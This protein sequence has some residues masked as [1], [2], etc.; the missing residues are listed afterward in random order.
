MK[1]GEFYSGKK[2]LITGHT[3]FKGAWLSILLNELGADIYGLSLPALPKALFTEA[4]I[5]SKVTSYKGDIRDPEVVVNVIKEVKPDV[6]FHLAAQALVRDSYEDPLNT[7]QVNVIGTLNILEAVRKHMSSCQLA[8]ITTDKVYNNLEWHYPYRECDELGGHDPYSSSKSCMELLISSYYKS[9]FEANNQ[10]KLLALRAG[11]VIGGGDWAKDRL[12]PD[13][14]RAVRNG[15]SVKL[16][17]PNAT[18]P[19]Q[20]VLDPLYGYM[21][22]IVIQGRGKLSAFET[23]NFGPEKTDGLTVEDFTKAA[24]QIF[25]KGSY[26]IDSDSHPHEAKMLRLDISKAKDLLKWR[27]QYDEQK[28]I[29]HTIRWYKETETGRMA[30]DMCIDQVHAFLKNIS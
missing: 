27:P 12:V 23:F 18:R 1:I 6:I 24:I 8:L 30:Y 22:A 26:D 14:I 17:N 21:T 25:E 4:N 13:I 16:R 11:N 2:V 9:Y 10:F 28:S 5:E 3:G 19:W 20:H 15:V 7:Y 29:E